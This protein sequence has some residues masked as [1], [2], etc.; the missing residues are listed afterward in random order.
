[1]AFA[2]GRQTERRFAAPAR[3]R[4]VDAA[5]NSLPAGNFSQ[6]IREFGCRKPRMVNGDIRKKFPC[7][8]GNMAT[9]TQ[10]VKYVS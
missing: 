7:H 1:M 9:E 6:F 3:S 2:A 5:S 4:F 8:F 10:L